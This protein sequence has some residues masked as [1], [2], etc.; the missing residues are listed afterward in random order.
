MEK[1]I[2][3][4]LSGIV[5]QFCYDPSFVN[6]SIVEVEKQP[7]V[8]IFSAS[9]LNERRRKKE[10]N[11]WRTSAVLKKLESTTEEEHFQNHVPA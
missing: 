5:I 7:S 9:D 2:S 10:Y 11:N 8:F 6:K 1:Y 4:G 3:A